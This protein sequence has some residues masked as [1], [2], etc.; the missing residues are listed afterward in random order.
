MSPSERAAEFPCFGSTCG[1]RVGCADERVGIAAIAAT[2]ATLA[3]WHARFSR[4]IPD[5]E[6]SRLNA[7][8][9]EEVPVSP[10]MARLINAIR[11]AGELTGG[12]VDGTLLE[13]IERSGY[14]EDLAERTPLARTLATAPARGPARP[15]PAARWR[16]LALDERRAVL[17]RPPGVRIDSGG[18]AK[19][20]FADLIAW[21]L[22]AHERFV[23]DCAGDLAFGGTGRV[24]RPVQ[25]ESP[26]DSKTV[27][28]LHLRAGGVATSGIGRRSWIGSDG[29]PRH[30]LLDPATGTPA[31]ARTSA[32]SALGATAVT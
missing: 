11:D 7:D 27:H 4:F 14:S 15:N 31:F 32:S 2:R 23:V 21:T 28:T 16:L 20:L 8:P 3:H 29:G 19:G 24:L 30:H 6:L 25:V 5:S 18:L 26:F 10:L 17:R 1:L 13:E 12:L 9:R 22:R